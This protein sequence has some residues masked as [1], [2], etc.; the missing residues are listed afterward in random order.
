[1]LRLANYSRREMRMYDNIPAFGTPIFPEDLEVPRIP[2]RGPKGEL[3]GDLGNLLKIVASGEA[4]PIHRQRIWKY[5]LPP[6]RSVIEPPD[7]DQKLAILIGLSTIATEEE[8][9]EPL[10]LPDQTVGFAVSRNDRIE[11]PRLLRLYGWGGRLARRIRHS[12]LVGPCPQC[13]KPRAPWHLHC[14]CCGAKWESENTTIGDGDVASPILRRLLDIVGVQDLHL[15][16]DRKILVH[17]EYVYSALNM[18][19]PGVQVVLAEMACMIDESI[20]FERAQVLVKWCDY[21]RHV[22]FRDPSRGKACSFHARVARQRRFDYA[23]NPNCPNDKE[24][25]RFCSRGVRP[26]DLLMKVSSW[27]RDGAKPNTTDCST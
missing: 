13:R 11:Y 22:Y 17:V 1:M 3:D 24:P 8:Y 12:R 7:R 23:V 2:G 14:P 25:V 6:I 16:N 26:R 9:P 15:L 27:R 20:E 10:H 18:T 21:G 19:A 4:S 5:G